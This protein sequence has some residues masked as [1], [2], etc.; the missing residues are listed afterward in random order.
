MAIDE[1][2]EEGGGEKLLVVGTRIDNNGVHRD[3]V[4]GENTSN[5][6]DRKI[7][8]AIGNLNGSGVFD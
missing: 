6:S 4:E 3:I 8:A 2:T 1:N 7:D 5:C